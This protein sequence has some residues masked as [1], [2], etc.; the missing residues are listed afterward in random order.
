MPIGDGHHL[1]SKRTRRLEQTRRIASLKAQERHCVC[2]AQHRRVRALMAMPS[3]SRPA[4]AWT[5]ADR[6]R[7]TA[8]NISSSQS[9][10]SSSTPRAASPSDAS[11]GDASTSPGRRCGQCSSKTSCQTRSY[12]QPCTTAPFQLVCIC[13]VREQRVK[14]LGAMR[15]ERWR[16]IPSCARDAAQLTQVKTCERHRRIGSFPREK[17]RPMLQQRI[18]SSTRLSFP[19][20]LYHLSNERLGA[21]PPRGPE[22][23]AWLEHDEPFAAAERV[24]RTGHRL[25]CKP[26]ATLA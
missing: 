18:A 25:N 10:R 15:T 6:T 2:R 20:S 19:W 24:R 21:D 7:D 5:V 16:P 26:P 13:D 1:C 17:P 9:A 22:A 14:V 4:L 23:L 3:R 11:T 12:A 8:R